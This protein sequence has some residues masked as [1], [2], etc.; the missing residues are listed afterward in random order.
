MKELRQ[1]KPR[2]R[3]PKH[4][5]FVR[6]QPCCVCGSVR[7]VEAAHVRMSCPNRGKS[8][9]GMQ[10]KPDDKWTVSLCAYHHRTGI[11]AQHVLGERTFWFHVHGRNPFEIAELLWIASGG[12]AR[13]LLPKPI[14]KPRE[15]KP[16]HRPAPKRAFP[17][18]RKLQSRGFSK[19]VLK[20]ENATQLEAAVL[21]VI[22]HCGGTRVNISGPRW[23]AKT[24]AAA[25][26]CVRKELL[27]GDLTSLDLTDAGQAVL[28]AA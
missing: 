27:S 10:E 9:T 15:I 4:L 2:E 8:E 12:A 23:N 18:G 17:K 19:G 11:A 13:A 20:M 26:E 24:K 25:K 22:A 14:R 21:K 16:E 5:A 3:D 1:R 28:K 7:M 6:A